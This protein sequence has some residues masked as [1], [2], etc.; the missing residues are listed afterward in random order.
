MGRCMA[1]SRIP[2]A[3]FSNL[4]TE[5][6]FWL[7]RGTNVPRL[8]HL[9]ARERPAR[10][11]RVLGKVIYEEYCE[12]QIGLLTDT[13]HPA[14]RDED[15]LWLA[16]TQAVRVAFPIDLLRHPAARAA[17]KPLIDAIDASVLHQEEAAAAEWIKHASGDAGLPPVHGRAPLRLRALQA[18][19]RGTDRVLYYEAVRQYRR[20]TSRDTSPSLII[21]SGWIR[22]GNGKVQPGVSE[23]AGLTDPDT[24]DGG[25]EPLG[26]VD[27]DGRV[28]WIARVIGYEGESVRIKEVL[29][30]VTTALK[31][32]GGGC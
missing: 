23:V 13:Q 11:A 19:E 20:P 18:F 3:P 27:I 1:G 31:K 25:S 22:S 16:T 30:N 29:P 10:V 5:Q 7:E 6:P 17:W 14:P 28:F 32:S 8:W 26:I 12:Y 21:A 2:R 9:P 15:P 4:D 24:Q